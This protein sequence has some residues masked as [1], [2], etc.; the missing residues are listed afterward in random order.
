[1]AVVL[2]RHVIIGSAAAWMTNRQNVKDLLVELKDASE[3]MVDLAYAAVFFNDEKMAEEVEP[4]RAALGRAPA[5]PAHRWRCSPRGA[6]RTPRAWPACCGSP[7]RSRG[8]A[9]PPSDIARV[10][11]ARLGH[12]RRAA[13][14]PP[15][16]RRD[17]RRGCGSARTRPAVGQTLARAVAARPR[18]ACG[19]WRSAAACDWEFD[20]G[21][22]D[23]VSRRR[24]AA[25][26]GARGGR[27]PGP[28]ARGRAADAAGTRRR[29]ARR[30]PSSTGRSTS[31]SR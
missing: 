23:V 6:P 29:R 1:M 30:C 26:P 2:A 25:G 17:D 19:S 13:A 22:D 31:W 21:P 12:P 18:P 28:R 15:P 4:A 27:E 10:V 3:L 20:P 11:A 7:T 8:S 14:R 9:T 24:R 5:A 16:R